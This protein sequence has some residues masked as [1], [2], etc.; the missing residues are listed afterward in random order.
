MD[1]Q[2]ALRLR[3]AIEATHLNATRFATRAGVP[4]GTI[5]KCL[6]G[7]VPTA[8]ILLRIARLSGKSVDWLLTGK[9]RW[10]GRDMRV[11]E[12]AAYYGRSGSARKPGDEEGIWVARL[13][14]VLRGGNRRKKQTIQDL[15]DMLSR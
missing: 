11:A 10:A 12:K 14:K 5:S 15:L 4:Q 9:E 3:G 2:F 7:H 13:L 1:K 8:R 6:N